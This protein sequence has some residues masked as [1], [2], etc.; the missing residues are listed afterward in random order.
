M[1]TEF[2]QQVIDLAESNA[3]TGNGGP[4]AAIVC[5]DQKI[6]AACTNNVTCNNDPT[7]HAEIMAIRTA[8]AELNTFSINRLRT[9]QQLLALPHVSGR[10]L[11]GKA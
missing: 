4:F 11:L 1:H 7:A 2:L 9:L 3:Y 10:H 8:C 6:I 5:R